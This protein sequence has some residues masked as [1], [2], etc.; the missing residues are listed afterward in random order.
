MNLWIFSGFWGALKAFLAFSLVMIIPGFFAGWVTNVFDFRRTTAISRFAL[1]VP[2]SV[3]VFPILVYLPWRFFSLHAVWIEFGVMVIAVGVMKAMEKESLRRLEGTYA[4][5]AA[6]VGLTAIAIWLVVAFA[7]LLDLRMGDRL[8][9]SVT[10][11]DYLSR[12]PIVKSIAQQEKLPALTPFLKLRG[13]TVP[14]HYHYFWPMVCG[15][16]L[17]SGEDAFNAR[18][19]AIGGTLWCGIALICAIV[20]Y[21]RIFLALDPSR[22][23]PY[24]IGLA[25]LGVTGLDILPVTLWDIHYLHEPAKLSP[26][27]ENWNEQITAWSGAMLWVPHHI[28]ALVACVMAFLALW[29][30]SERAERWPGAG[31]LA[32]AALALASS[33]GMSV[34]V[35]FTFACI[36]IVWALV[37]LVRR[38]PKALASVV[39]VG[40]ISLMLA[41]PFFLEV[42]SP[43]PAHESANL[44]HFQVRRF[45]LFSYYDAIAPLGLT[46]DTQTLT[47][48]FFRLVFLPLNYLL[49]LGVYFYAGILGVSRLWRTRNISNRDVAA[50]VMLAVSAILGTFVASNLA[51][52]AND[53]G[54][55]SFMPA[56]FILLLWTA[57]FLSDSAVLR[58]SQ[59][60]VL[61]VLLT[62]GASSAVADL[63]LLR[64]FDRFI[65]TP[66]FNTL[67]DLPQVDHR[68]GRRNAARADS[69]EWIRT[70]TAA[71]A[72]V[73][74]NPDQRPYFYGL[75][76][77]RAGLAIS[78]ECAAFS[79]RDKECGQI[80][81]AVRPLFSGGANAHTLSD[82]CEAYPLDVLVV[83][84]SDPVWTM[85]DNWMNYYTP[86]FSNEFTR[87]FSCQP[88]RL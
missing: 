41:A 7:S 1:V 29:C 27:I 67:G 75:Y 20:L 40:A 25:L 69:Y 14:L 42:R 31:A 12:V 24:V 64:L 84:D 68:L 26:S 76:A 70:H 28:A 36:L 3:S 80:Q 22:T 79:G 38:Q 30:D 5:K 17:S 23:R 72:V 11:Y 81:A 62:I 39:A 73:E 45:Y 43:T 10:V 15:L 13:E 82:V 21:Q 52:G 59:R 48:S 16:V 54:W 78:G 34:F 18:D 50:A 8:Y 60:A 77:E 4:R 35:T 6:L 47:S 9:R 33:A 51:D 61:Y 37:M 74:P 49:E 32:L 44:M 2:L 85:K 56:Q 53:F 46:G 65:D 57:D 19:A 86:V 71:N 58:K 87:V 66:L 83:T 88:K 63:T 55:R